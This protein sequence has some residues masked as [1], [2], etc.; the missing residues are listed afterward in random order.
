MQP[1]LPLKLGETLDT[2]LLDLCRPMTGGFAH[3]TTGGFAVGVLNRPLDPQDGLGRLE[4]RALCRLQS[5]QW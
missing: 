3:P 2:W 5:K 1:S 4:N